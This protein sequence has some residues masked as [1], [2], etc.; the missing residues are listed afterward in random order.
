LLSF[1]NSFALKAL[2]DSFFASTNSIRNRPFY[3]PTHIL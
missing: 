2:N 1:L 3:K